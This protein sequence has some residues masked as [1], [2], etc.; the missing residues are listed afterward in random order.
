EYDRITEDGLLQITLAVGFDEHGLTAAEHHEILR[1]LTEV[2]GFTLD[3][4]RAAEL[5]EEAGRPPPADTTT[6]RPELRQGARDANYGYTEHRGH[7]DEPTRI[8]DPTG[9]GDVELLQLKLNWHLSA[10]R[11]L[12]LIVDGDFGGAT[13]RAVIAFKRFHNIRPANAVVDAATWTALDQTPQL[14]PPQGRHA[15][16][17]RPEYD[18]ITEDGLLQI[19]LAVGF[20]EHGLTAAEHHELVRGLTEVRGFTLDPD[21]AAELHEQAGRPPPAEGGELFVK[22]NVATSLSSPVHCVL[23]LIGPAAPGADGTASATAAA[24]ALDESEIFEYGGHARYGTGPDFDRNYTIRVHWDQVPSHQR[25][26][27]SG[28]QDMT[29]DEFMRAFNV[30]D[31]RRGITTFDRMREAG[32]LTFIAHPEGNLGINPGPVTH[33]DTLGN[34]LIGL[35]TAGQPL[36]L[37]PAVSDDHYRLWLFN[38]CVTRE[39]MNALRTSGNTQMSTRQLDVTTNVVPPYVITLAEGLLA[40][41]D[42]VLAQEGARALVDRMENAHPRSDDRYGSD[43]FQDNGPGVRQ[44]P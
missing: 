24:L 6:V 19:T 16:G 32:Q 2:R 8:S 4:D 43:G 22:E 23:R 26:R 27:H 21:R 29:S 17:P 36:R 40:Y 10:M 25:G 7:P 38:G 37:S 44:A 28:D 18:R 11:R 5:H 33:P 39:Y 41:L 20:D 14:V 13:A 30:G 3:P 35:A 34:H 42:G 1:G 9:G 31:N 15:L 12:G